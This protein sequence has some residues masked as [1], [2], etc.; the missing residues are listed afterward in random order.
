MYRPAAPHA[1]GTLLEMVIVIAVLAIV[2]T[3]ARPRAEA[4]SPAVAEA[5]ASE[6]ASAMRF[7]RHEAMRTRAYHAVSFDTQ[8]HS[9][10]IYRLTTLLLAVEDTSQPVMYPVDKRAYRIAFGDN[11]NARVTIMGASFRYKDGATRK[12]ACFGPDGRPADVH[13]LLLKDAEPLEQDGQVTIKHGNLE[14]TV[15][16]DFVTGRVSL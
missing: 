9:L 16:L 15:R 4:I 1:G 8:Q 5:A 3:I 11:P 13:G 14:R 2:M 10:R 7:A 12:Y 6:V